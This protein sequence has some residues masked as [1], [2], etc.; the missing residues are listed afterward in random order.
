LSAQRP[1][2]G[3][4]P[5]SLVSAAYSLRTIFEKQNTNEWVEPGSE[6]VWTTAAVWEHTTGAYETIIL[7]EDREVWVLIDAAAPQPVR[8]PRGADSPD[9]LTRARLGDRNAEWVAH[10][11]LAEARAEIESLVAGRPAADHLL[12]YA[13]QDKNRIDFYPVEHLKPGT[14]L[15]DL[16]WRRPPRRPKVK[17]HG[18]SYT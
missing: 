6:E 13:R 16:P 7:D 10:T 12:I 17:A 15:A 14:A 11:S 5:G 2:G 8:P 18:D 3:R 1:T 4:P 9:F